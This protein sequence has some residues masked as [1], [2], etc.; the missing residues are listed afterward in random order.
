GQQFAE[1]ECEGRL[2]RR[3]CLRQIG[4][5]ELIATLLSATLEHVHDFAHL[6]ILEQA[7]HQLA[8]RI[9]PRLLIAARQQQ[10]RL[11]AQQAR[12]HLEV[13]GRLVDAEGSDTNQK[14]LG[15]VGDGDV[16]DVELLFANE[17]E[18]Q[19]ERAR[20]RLE[21]HDE[22]IVGNLG[23]G[24]AVGRR[25]HRHRST[26]RSTMLSILSPVACAGYIQ[27]FNTPGVTYNSTI[28]KMIPYREICTYRSAH[29][30]GSRYFMT[31]EPSSGGMGRR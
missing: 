16:V 8:A 3:G 30:A 6:L 10:L 19:I 20:E 1:R 13:I 15:D 7:P 26:N 28:S 22:C 31:C 17:R 18:E 5:R 12:R 2:R 4:A 29:D 21:L 14:L 23:R 27:V 24:V 25:S 11:D 9:L